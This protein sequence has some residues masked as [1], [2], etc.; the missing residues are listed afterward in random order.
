MHDIYQNQ[1]MLGIYCAYALLMLQRRGAPLS[2][3]G[4]YADQLEEIAY[5]LHVPSICCTN[6]I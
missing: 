2:L 1:G 6:I 3:F 5:V 4:R